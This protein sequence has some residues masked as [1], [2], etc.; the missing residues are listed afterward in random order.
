M[1]RILANELKI[2][3]E[4]TATTTTTIVCIHFYFMY[5]VHNGD[6]RY[7]THTA[8]MYKATK[9]LFISAYA[10]IA[11]NCDALAHGI[12]SATD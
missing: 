6:S 5:Y 12:V 2:K 10:I 11:K 9:V 7:Q 3:N 1:K 8:H 4:A